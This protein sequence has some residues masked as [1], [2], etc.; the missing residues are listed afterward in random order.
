MP[1]CREQE[2]VNW[3]VEKVSGLKTEETDAV[4]NPEY[5]KEYT[6]KVTP[7]IIILQDGTIREWFGGVV[8]PE[9]LKKT[10]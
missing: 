7:A 9:P 2:P 1:G 8:H 10:L 6:P 3:D 5:V 4:K